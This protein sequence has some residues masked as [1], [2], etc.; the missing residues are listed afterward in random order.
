MIDCSTLASRCSVSANETALC[1]LIWACKWILLPM[2]LLVIGFY[3]FQKCRKDDNT[4]QEK[5]K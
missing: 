3:I 1:S 2:A 4:A 5:T